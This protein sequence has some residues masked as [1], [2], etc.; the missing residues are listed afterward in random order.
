MCKIYLNVDPWCDLLSSVSEPWTRLSI[1]LIHSAEVAH[2]THTTEP[3]ASHSHSGGSTT[4]R[5]NRS[6]AI[7]LSRPLRLTPRWASPVWPRVYQRHQRPPSW[8]NGPKQGQGT[9]KTNGHTRLCLLTGQGMHAH[10]LP[11]LEAPARGTTKDRI[12]TSH[13]VNVVALRKPN[14]VAP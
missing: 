14:S 13:K 4:C 3:M 10:N 12:K 8:Q 11:S 1:D 9:I 6:T 5:Q 7:T 2:C